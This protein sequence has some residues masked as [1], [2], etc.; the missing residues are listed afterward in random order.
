M[1]M[2]TV[3]LAEARRG[4]NCKLLELVLGEDRAY[5]ITTS[6][7]YPSLDAAKKEFLKGASKGMAEKYEKQISDSIKVYKETD[8][9]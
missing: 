5:R 9:R 1:T 6:R 2:R 4:M 7:R 8:K 3:I